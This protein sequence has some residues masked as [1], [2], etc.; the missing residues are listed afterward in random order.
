MDRDS[1]TLLYY[2]TR[3]INIGLNQC[4]GPNLCVV[5]RKFSVMYEAGLISLWLYKENNT[6]RDWKIYLLYIFPLSSKLLWLRCSNFFNPSKK[7]SFACAANRKI[8]KA[9][10]LSA[11]LCSLRGTIQICTHILICVTD[12]ITHWRWKQTQSPRTPLDFTPTAYRL[13]R[14]LLYA[15]AIKL[16]IL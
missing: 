1:P 14:L 7:N 6:I 5:E 12:Y 16:Y 4:N 2:D 8:G 10:D 11:P 15:V 13:V 3:W 9:K